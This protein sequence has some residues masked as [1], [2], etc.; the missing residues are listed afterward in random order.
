MPLI[1]ILGQAAAD[2]A[3]SSFAGAGALLLGGGQQM[4]AGRQ[5]AAPWSDAADHPSARASLLDLVRS[6]QAAAVE[7]SRDGHQSAHTDGCY[8]C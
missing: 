5:A 8:Y 2:A 7:A 1:Q 4:K 3:A 6:V